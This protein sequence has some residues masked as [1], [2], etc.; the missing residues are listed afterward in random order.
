[1]KSIYLG[2]EM[3][4]GKPTIPT[5]QWRVVVWSGRN[6]CQPPATLMKEIQ[7][8][9]DM[10]VGDGVQRE[11]I[12]VHLECSVENDYGDYVGT[13]SIEITGQRPAT[14]AEVVVERDRMQQAHTARKQAEITRLK[15]QLAELERRR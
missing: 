7:E 1:M 2:T 8:T 5:V 11:G 14:E 3:I 9:V 6:E 12:T 10:L 13:P 15:N 4:K